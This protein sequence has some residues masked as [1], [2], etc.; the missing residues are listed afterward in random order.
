M[1]SRMPV[2][3]GWLSLR[4]SLVAA[5][6]CGA[7]LSLP[8]A[9]AQSGAAGTDDDTL[10]LE[11][12]VVTGSRI[13]GAAPVGATVTTLG[14]D[15]IENAGQVTL[16]R[17]IKELPQVLDLGFSETS[18]AQS[19]GNGN[20]TW[21]S[22]INLRGLSPYATLIITDGHRMTT[23]G[24]AISP[25]VI[26]TLGVD[27]IEVI[28][29]GTS[30]IY[31]SDAVAGVVN[32]IPRR[33]LDGAE[34]FYRRGSDTEGDFNEWN[35]GLAWG[36]VF[37][38]GQVMLAY[39]H[40]FRS[41]L[42]GADR[43][44]FASDQT[45]RGG[46][47]YRTTQCSPGTLTYQGRSYALP[48]QFTA[49][50]ANTLVAGTS[51]KC[52]IQDGMDLLPQQKYDSV[53]STATFEFLDG[54]EFI[55]DGYYNKRK[56]TRQPGAITT[57]LSVP[58]TN[59]FFVA[60]SFYT[61][62]NYTIAYNFQNDVPQNQLYGYQSNWQATPGLRIRLPHDWTFEGIYGFGKDVD[63]A[64]A[65][66][67]LVAAALTTAL[68]S[69]DPATAFDPYGLG[70]TT[71][72]TK[73]LIFDADATFP[74]NGDLKTWQAGFNGSL[75]SLPGGAVKAALGYEGQDF[76]MT[77]AAGTADVSHYSRKV[78]SEYLELLLPI[79]GSANSRKGIQQL[80][81][82]AAVR[83]DDYSDVGSTTNPRFGVNYRPG[84]KVKLRA[85]YGTSFR[86]PTFPEIFG[87]STAIYIQPFQ[88]PSGTPVSVPGYKLGSGPNPDVG[89]ETATTW[90]F[91]AD[92]EPAT[93]LK[94]GLTYFDINFKDTISNLLSN[95]SVLN[96]EAEYEGSGV[97]LRGQ[98]AYDRIIDLS[99]NGFAGTGPIAFRAGGAGYP[100]GAFDCANGVDPTHADCIFVDGRSLNL[101]RTRMRGID[102]DTRYRMQVGDGADSLTFQFTG[103]YLTA[104]DVAYTPGGSYSDQLNRIF[105]PLTFKGRA[106]VTWDHGP[107]NTRL[108]FS[109]VNAYDNDTV[110]PV[111]RVRPYMPVDLSFGWQLDESFNVGHVNAL[112]LGVELRNLFDTDPPFVNS[113]PGPNAGGGYD[114][115]I[116]NPVG[117]ELAVSLRARF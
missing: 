41:N 111:Q 42:A 71:D 106:S 64:D 63:R 18:R 101:G 10:E 80:E 115:T 60:P 104:Y 116:A 97:I 87:N 62:G 84:D 67:G 7:V 35:A 70:R 110:T 95:L 3:G 47:D 29:D 8:V 43:T 96:Q 22:S 91:G 58:S 32:L 33:T 99:T 89:P 57:N 107:I 81:M 2:V 48:A 102:F 54:F 24:R 59:A 25:S 30:A 9:A 4:T 31:G 56:F 79:V 37:D 23:N 73:A 36:K 46:A 5:G 86:A 38:R 75:F 40:A 45:A 109:R 74:T 21:S 98:E 28:A 85:S 72:A 76:A 77:L 50:N 16:D 15:E 12:V 94:I 51:N 103:T 83:F 112:T 93:G 49:A 113:R 92:I 17:M 34:A 6:I 52:D 11:A 68:A 61:T 26:P 90:T 78:N 14:R 117:L 44:F 20:A 88:N 55:F 13:Q 82:T 39:E 105:Q 108:M 19:A 66:A 53:S 114:A 1:I 65:G 27:R 100:P 69:S